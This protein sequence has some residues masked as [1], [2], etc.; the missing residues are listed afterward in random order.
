MLLSG[1]NAAHTALRT[2]HS[3]LST[4]QTACTRAHTP[5]RAGTYAVFS[6]KIFH[7][8]HH[9]MSGFF[10]FFNLLKK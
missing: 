9:K 8:K 2:A 3:T 1:A 4:P 10:N 6:K 7:Q 5:L